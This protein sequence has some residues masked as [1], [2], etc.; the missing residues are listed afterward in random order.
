[1]DSVLRAALMYGIL[2]LLFRATG[3]RTLHQMTSFDIVLLLFIGEATQQA[4]LGPD[5]S[6]TNALLVIVTLLAIDVGLSLIKRR[7]QCAER[8][9]EGLPTILLIHGRPL[10]G[11]LD[12]ARISTGDVL[13]AA[14]QLHGITKLADID[15]AVLEVDGRISI[16]P[17]PGR[18]PAPP[19]DR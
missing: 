16:V 7:W 19:S 10:E 4:L 11:R 1:M 14:R 3:R 8:L 9:I 5:S 18:E 12:R 17:Q 6:L 2:L 15:L 13:Q